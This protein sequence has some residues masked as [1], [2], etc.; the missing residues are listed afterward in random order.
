M[1]FPKR[2]FKRFRKSNRRN[3]KKFPRKIYKKKY[4]KQK[5]F[6]FTRTQNVQVYLD[7]SN[8]GAEPD[9]AHNVW[10]FSNNSGNPAVEGTFKLADLPSYTEFTNLFDQYRICGIKW[11]LGT[12]HNTSEVNVEWETD[13]TNTEGHLVVHSVLDND[14]SSL[15]YTIKN[16]NEYETYKRYILKS[17][18]S[19]Y[20]K[21]SVLCMAYKSA[22]STGYITKYNQ[23][24][25]ATD[26]T[27]PH[28]GIKFLIEE[29][30]QYSVGQDAEK[31]ELQLR[32]T[33]YIQC[34]GV[35]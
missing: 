7:R 13:L 28:Y 24:V 1:A 2:V 12:Y 25:D 10:A 31:L 19:R 6:N 33:Y 11:E 26:S 22:V 27:V 4:T 35:H 16:Y 17:K 21:P 23:W 34:R 32:I 8:A 18:I 20:F 9:T 30:R 15:I 5:V 3:F 29:P 14:D